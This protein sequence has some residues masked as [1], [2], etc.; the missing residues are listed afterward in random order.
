M[1]ERGNSACI[2]LLAV[3]DTRIYFSILNTV[4]I[5][6]ER[7]RVLHF[8]TQSR[9]CKSVEPRR[10]LAAWRSFRKG[11][12][13]EKRTGAAIPLRSAPI[14]SCLPL[15]PSNVLAVPP[16]GEHAQERCAIEQYRGGKGGGRCR[17][18]QPGAPWYGQNGAH[19]P[20]SSPHASDRL[21]SLA[22]AQMQAQGQ[23]SIYQAW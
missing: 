19:F 1:T 17:A 16:Q 23:R 18:H 12:R 22:P 6:T 5:R 13:R 8:A 3:I 4:S 10:H 11:Q 9:Q 21:R 14:S 20:Y 7:N 2:A 15:A